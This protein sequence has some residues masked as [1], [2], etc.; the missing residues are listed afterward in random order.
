ML[1]KALYTNM[2]KLPILGYI[3]DTD[4]GGTVPIDLLP[5]INSQDMSLVIDAIDKN[6]TAI[7]PEDFK[8]LFANAKAEDVFDLTQSEIYDMLKMCKEAYGDEAKELDLLHEKGV[9]IDLMGYVKVVPPNILITHY[10]EYIKNLGLDTDTNTYN[11]IQ[12]HYK[13]DCKLHFNA[14]ALDKEPKLSYKGKQL[15]PE[16]DTTK[17]N[18]KEYIPYIAKLGKLNNYHI[19]M[20]RDYIKGKDVVFNFNDKR[21]IFTPQG[22]YI[23]DDEIERYCAIK[24]KIKPERVESILRFRLLTKGK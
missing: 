13:L 5:N 7:L 9:Y 22:D 19:V 3:S 12:A 10:E 4:L 23:L 11:D 16:I 20:V 17:F 24:M 2:F 21:F 18:P 6:I 8:V 14:L 15:L 1:R